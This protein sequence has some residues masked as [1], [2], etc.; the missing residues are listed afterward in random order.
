M[1]IVFR[2]SQTR[3]FTAGGESI[4]TQESIEDLESCLIKSSGLERIDV[5][6]RLASLL[7]QHEPD[8]SHELFREALEISTEEDYAGGEA[9][10][11]FGLGECARVSG[12][13]LKA[14]EQY[15]AA[16]RI[17]DL[18]DNVLLKG[19]SLR[20]LGDMQYFL[21]NLD[22]SLRYY[23]QALRLFEE[24]DTDETVKDSR[25]HVG[26]LFSAIGN[27]LKKSGDRSGAM[28]YYRQ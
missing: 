28:S 17:A 24:A 4:H 18:H 14:L 16:L 12:D 23:L 25:L 15:S 7:V 3:G 6:N 13:Y 9:S 26:H 1:A 5:L 21:T 20:R 2:G 10:A 22:L 11:L 19:K 8:R 27:V